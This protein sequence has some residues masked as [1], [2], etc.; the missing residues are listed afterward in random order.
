MT[1]TLTWHP[2][3]ERPDLVAD[4]VR[5][6]LEATP[7]AGSVEVTE[8]DPDLADTQALVD[9]TDVLLEESAN[10]IVVLGRRGE[11]ERIAAALVLATTRADVN[12]TV[13]KTLDVRKASFLPM[14]RAVAETGME[15]GGITPVG[16]PGDWP[17]L[18]DSRVVDSEQVVIGS[19]LRRSKL[20][21]PGAL[22]ADLPGVQVIEGLA[23]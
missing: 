23:S 20:R 8:I 2:F 21:L 16:L 10:C 14:E 15:F 1:H 19:G 18:V 13:R 7:L 5:A 12:T 11:I 17:V 6:A 4:P 22:V 3:T 9:S